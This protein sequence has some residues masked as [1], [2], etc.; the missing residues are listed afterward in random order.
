MLNGCVFRFDQLH[1]PDTVRFV[2]VFRME[3]PAAR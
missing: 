3:V 2:G 1:T